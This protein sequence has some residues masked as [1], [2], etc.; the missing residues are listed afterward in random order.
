MLRARLH[1]L[2]LMPFLT[3]LFQ[4]GT[5]VAAQNGHFSLSGS[6][7]HVYNLVGNVQVVAGTVRRFSS[8]SPRRA[9]TAPG[10][11]TERSARTERSSS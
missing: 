11:A 3:L 2:P 8:T 5:P 10:S 7:V 4:P 6:A 1:V 9:R